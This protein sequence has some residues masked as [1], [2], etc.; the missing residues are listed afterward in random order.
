MNEI[1]QLVSTLGLPTV[2]VLGIALAAWRVGRYIATR[3]L[4]EDRGILTQ[5]ASR[6]SA[7][8]EDTSAHLKRQ[9]QLAE[10]NAVVLT[11][12]AALQANPDGPC[13]SV[14]TN[15]AIIHLAEALEKIA[16][17]RGVDIS[18][19]VRAIRQRLARV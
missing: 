5:L 13:S 2:L 6:H 14:G 19:Q 4:D 11:N 3:L 1:A 7:F 9:E 18:D 10:Q 12:L 17:D 15:E 16:E 8:L